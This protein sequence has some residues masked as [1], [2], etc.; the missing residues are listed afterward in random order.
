MGDA[1]KKEPANTKEV[2]KHNRMDHQKRNPETTVTQT[3]KKMKREKKGGRPKRDMEAAREAAG[4]SEAVEA[5]GGGKFAETDNK[6][7]VAGDDDKYAKKVAEDNVLTGDAVDDFNDANLRKLSSK[8]ASIKKP[9]PEHE[10]DESTRRKLK[11]HPT[12][13]SKTKIKKD[14]RVDM[15]MKD[16]ASQKQE[17]PTV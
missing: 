7:E 2:A 17:G 4:V 14:E 6:V 15:K 11:N 10:L 9:Q 8:S 13:S 3:A 16:Q 1:S 5:S 12:V